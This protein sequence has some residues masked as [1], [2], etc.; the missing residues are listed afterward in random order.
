MQHQLI[1]IEEEEETKFGGWKRKDN[2]QHTSIPCFTK[3]I[4]ST[5]PSI[6]QHKLYIIVG[7]AKTDF[8]TM[9]HFQ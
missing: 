6:N 9:L 3:W 7:Y 2:L 8:T 5:P 4:F 1:I